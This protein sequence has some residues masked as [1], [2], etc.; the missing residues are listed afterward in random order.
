MWVGL[1]QSVESLKRKTEVPE[2]EMILPSD[3]SCNITSP[4]SPVSHANF[5][6]ASLYNHMSNS[7]KSIPRS[8]HIYTNPMNSN[9]LYNSDI[10]PLCMTASVFF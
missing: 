1:I 6:L 9:F 3:S 4:V 7:F 2:E 8:V 10:L 5:R